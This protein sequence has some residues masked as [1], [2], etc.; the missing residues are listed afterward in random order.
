MEGKEK[1][2]YLVIKLVRRC[3]AIIWLGVI[4][5]LTMPGSASQSPATRLKVTVPKIWDAKQLAGWAIP[6]AGVNAT[7]NFYTEEEYYATPMDNLRTYPVYHPGYEPKGYRE[8]I[9]RQGAQPLIDP[10]KLK[11]EQDWIDAGRRVFDELDVPEARSNDPRA[12][13]YVG[14]REAIK[15]DGVKITKDGVIPTLRWVVDKDGQL[16]LGL[17]ECASCH[18]RV[19][20]DGTLL[21]GAQGNHNL[22]AEAIGILLESINKAREEQGKL[23]PPNVTTGTDPSLALKTR[24][25]TG[26]Y[27]VP[28]LKGLWYRGLIEHS[29]SIARLEE[30][31]DPKRLRD[32]YIPSGWK[33]PGVKTRAVKGHEY[34]LNLSAA[35][36]RALIAFLKV[37]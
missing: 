30:W 7:P 35:D 8:W 16:R 9:K 11:T 22:G 36:K 33:G 32:D 37:L 6:V 18:T 27:K 19:L 17:S 34:G 10:A 21:G 23:L 12:I 31:F 26:Y 28:S 3:A 20:D 25:G 15:R 4:A 13:A 14:D 24:K 2:G 29:G 1:Q 5:V